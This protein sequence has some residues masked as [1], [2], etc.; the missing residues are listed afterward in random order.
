MTSHRR[1]TGTSH[2]QNPRRRTHTNDTKRRADGGLVMSLLWLVAKAAAVIWYGYTLVDML[3]AQVNT[4]IMLDLLLALLVSVRLGR[5]C[6]TVIARHRRLK[7][8]REHPDDYPHVHAKDREWILD[9]E[10]MTWLERTRP[11]GTAIDVTGMEGGG[12]S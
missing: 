10:T 8:M 5:D 11:A 1:T 9:P 7:D 12:Q 6:A 3:V 4:T 2:R